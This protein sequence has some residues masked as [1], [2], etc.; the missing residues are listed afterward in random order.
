MKLIFL[1]TGSPSSLSNHAALYIND[2]TLIDCGNGMYKVLLNNHIDIS[3]IRYILITH[4]H[5]DHI[6]DIPLLLFGISNKNPKQKITF[7]GN[8]YLKR[9]I[10]ELMKV[11]HPNTYKEILNKLNVSYLRCDNLHNFILDNKI[12]LSTFKV[13]HGD[14]KECYGYILNQDIAYTGD[15]TYNKNIKDIA[16]KVKYLITE[17]T[18]T[19]GTIH[20][21]G[22]KNIQDLSNHNKHTQ[23][24]ITH[25]GNNSK[26]ILSKTIFINHNVHIAKDGEIMNIK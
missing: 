13:I 22:V 3:K 8:R 23:F 7:I 2:D 20:H 9:K 11:A 21:M 1:G 10:H 25:M 18:M 16:K 26:K 15:T 17:C 12:R 6:F 19:K 5:M 4:L 24:I 14:L